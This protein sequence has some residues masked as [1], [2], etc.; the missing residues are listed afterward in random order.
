M[1]EPGDG[2]CGACGV[3]KHIER[4]AEKRAAQMRSRAARPA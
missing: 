3:S 4:A 2:A 1:S